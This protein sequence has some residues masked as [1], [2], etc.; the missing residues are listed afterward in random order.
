MP[1]ERF[2]TVPVELPNGVTISVQALSPG[3]ARDVGSRDGNFDLGEVGR[4]LTGLAELAKDAI[5]KATPDTASV[6]FGMDIAL[7]SGKL[8]ALLVSGS[9]TASLKVTL[10]WESAKSA[11]ASDPQ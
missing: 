5:A 1:G 3:G 8:T 7:E 2:E 4:A 10:G 9:T 6:E 11:S